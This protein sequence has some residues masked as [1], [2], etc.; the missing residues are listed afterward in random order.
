MVLKTILKIIIIPFLII[1]FVMAVKS[2]L[3]VFQDA[4]RSFKYTKKKGYSVLF[5]FWLCMPFIL[6]PFIGL[7]RNSIITT[8]SLA[9]IFGILA[10]SNPKD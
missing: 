5:L 6:I 3:Q 2:T 1:L 10:Y 9:G 4:F 7:T 8:W